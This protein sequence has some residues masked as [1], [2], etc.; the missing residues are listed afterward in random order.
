MVKIN[1]K[2]KK[3]GVRKPA[4][5]RPAPAKK[6][7]ARKPKAAS[8]KPIRKTAEDKRREQFEH[9]LTDV[10]KRG[11]QRGFISYGELLHMFPRIE[12]DILKLEE[13]YQRIAEAGIDVIE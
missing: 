9:Q 4:I 10:L 6:T 1:K 3:V 13:L 7:R 11:R 12:D 5:K 2:K 8:K